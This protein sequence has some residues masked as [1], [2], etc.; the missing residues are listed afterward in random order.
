MSKALEPKHG[1]SLDQQEGQAWGSAQ[2][3]S[4]VR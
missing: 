2:A 3:I 4:A 1:E